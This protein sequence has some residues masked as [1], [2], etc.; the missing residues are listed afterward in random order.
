MIITPELINPTRTAGQN[1]VI[2]VY[3]KENE[4]VVLFKDQK[5][6]NGYPVTVPP[7]TAVALALAILEA[8]GVPIQR[9]LGMRMLQSKPGGLP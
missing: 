2:E 4:V 8:A 1:A 3:K 5:F 6:R 9:E 7:R